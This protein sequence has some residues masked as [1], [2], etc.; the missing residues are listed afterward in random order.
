[1][2]G[3]TYPFDRLIKAIDSL[4]GFEV[5]AQIGDSS[6]K[7]KNINYSKILSSHEINKKIVWSDVIISHAGVGSIIDLI[8]LE[9][10]FILFPRLKKFG[11]AVDDHQTEIC[12]A[13]EKKYNVKWTTNEKELLKL[14]KDL[15]PVKI[16]K[17]NKLVKEIDKII[18]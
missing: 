1:M 6:L 14:L 11:E 4:K 13:F 9:K 17:K 16:N 2:V 7:P 18:K 15:R 8:S 5:F 3:S 10:K 12:E